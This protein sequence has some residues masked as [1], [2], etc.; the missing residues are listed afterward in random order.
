MPI[1]TEHCPVTHGNYLSISQ[2]GFDEICEI[3]REEMHKGES[4]YPY[5]HVTCRRV[6]YPEEI[7][8]INIAKINGERGMSKTGTCESCGQV[9]SLQNSHGKSVCSTCSVVRGAAKNRPAAVLDAVRDFWPLLDLFTREEVEKAAAKVGTVDES[10]EHL[11]AE[12][13][14]AKA[15]LEK[16]KMENASLLKV[17]EECRPADDLSDLAFDLAMGCI[18]GEITGLKP[19]QLMAIRGA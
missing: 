10:I 18:S 15:D 9:K 16:L 14:A 12:L 7:V 11:R 1:Y 3:K 5:C 19:E 2:N 6:R 4:R 8:F 13:L 17:V